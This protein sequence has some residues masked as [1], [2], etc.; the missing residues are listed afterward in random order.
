MLTLDG[1]FEGPG[2]DISW[3]LFDEELERYI[4]E[5]QQTADTLLFGRV[6]YEGMASY[7]P[8]AVGVIAD[9]MNAIPKVVFS[10]T[11]DTADWN[12]SRLV[13]DNV[14]EEVRRLKAQPGG[15]IFVFGSADFADTLFEH[16]LVDEVRIGL[17]PVVLG[18]GTPFFKDSPHRRQLQLLQLRPLKSGVVI[19]HY[20]PA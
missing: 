19:L 12:N 11:L 7:W 4:L 13:K 16:G 3:F 6:T 5:T 1:R 15:D 2:Q 14:A 8:T 18:S 17:N 10:R 20:Q 9:F